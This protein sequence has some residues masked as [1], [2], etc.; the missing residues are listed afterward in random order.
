MEN[1]VLAKVNG[2]EITDAILDSTIASLPPERRSYFDSEYGRNQLLEQL[3]SVELINA[4]G[5]ELG[6]D[7]DPH[8]QAQVEQP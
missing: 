3:V 2:I 1:H 5:T 6:L 7:N 8:Y 4:F